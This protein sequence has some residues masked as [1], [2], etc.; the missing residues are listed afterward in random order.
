VH[1]PH[2]EWTRDRL[3]EYL[4]TTETLTLEFKSAR[5]LI[6]DSKRDKNDRI[7]EAAIDVAS[8]ANEQGGVIVYGS[9][10]KKEGEVRRAVRLEDG[11]CPED[12]VSRSWFLQFSRDR[13][14]P[15]LPDIDAVEVPLNHSG[16]RFA[17]VVL[18]PQARGVAR[19][20]GRAGR[21]RDGGL[22]PD[23]GQLRDGHEP[24]R[25]ARPDATPAGA[26]IDAPERVPLSAAS[27]ASVMPCRH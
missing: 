5:A 12:K 24:G 18:V 9:E 25:A 19:A 10:E 8:M 11:F 2:S 16:E 4:G 27:E 20:A 3:E 26:Q 21:G 6:A 14:H 15:P 7:Q 23:A 1:H 17:L 13:V 22:G